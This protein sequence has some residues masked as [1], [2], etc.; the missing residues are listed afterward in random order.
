MSPR[1]GELAVTHGP[2]VRVVELET[3]DGVDG[4]AV[5][6][7]DG[8][9]AWIPLGWLIRVPMEQQPNGGK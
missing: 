5:R 9:E 8:F 2:L 4:A 3:R 1:V 6:D 7:N